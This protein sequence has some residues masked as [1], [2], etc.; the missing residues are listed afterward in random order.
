MIHLKGYVWVINIEENNQWESS[1]HDYKRSG[2]CKSKHD[3]KEKWGIINPF[4]YPTKYTLG[5]DCI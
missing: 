5:S 3:Y 4:P 2:E 1:K